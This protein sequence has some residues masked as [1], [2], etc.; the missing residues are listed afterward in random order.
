MTPDQIGQIDDWD[1]GLD[2]VFQAA[3][4]TRVWPELFVAQLMG[5]R[6]LTASLRVPAGPGPHPLVIY[7]HGG[8]WLKGHPHLVSP[9]NRA[10]RIPERLLA[11]GY[12]VAAISYRFVG[13]GR[14]PMQIHDCAAAV[15]FLRAYA[16]RL[17]LDPARFAA[18]GQ[19]AGAQMAL[20]L[21]M[22]LPEALQGQVGVTGPSCRVQAV[23]DWYG[24]TDLT[25][26]YRGYS[27]KQILQHPT[28][29]M[30]RLLGG[31]EEGQALAEAASP[32]RHV[33]A[34]AAPVLIQHGTADTMVDFEHAVRMHDALRT[35][36]VPVELIPLEGAEHGFPG[37]DTRHLMPQM[38]GFLE[39]YL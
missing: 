7:I 23:V 1:T 25:M 18:F 32:V 16:P 12:A 10:L 34:G 21:G 36:G 27:L 30:A 22:N 3:D 33:D 14:F 24:I 37:A 28:N 11:A 39:T 35:A 9:V 20:L 17:D 15:R 5:W 31:P 19:S 26:A 13:E 8:S 6:P 2:R 4:G 38:L 29:P